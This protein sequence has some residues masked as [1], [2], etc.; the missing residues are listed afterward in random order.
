[1]SLVRAGKAKAV[2]YSIDLHNVFE[3]V[4]GD[5]FGTKRIAGEQ[6]DIGVIAGFGFDVRSGHECSFQWSK[7]LRMRYCGRVKAHALRT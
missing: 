6:N 1:M 3:E 4:F 2:A 5:V 7:D